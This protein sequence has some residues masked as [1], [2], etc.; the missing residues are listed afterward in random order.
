ML[1]VLLKL[2]PWLYLYGG[3]FVRNGVHPCLRLWLHVHFL[4]VCVDYG[5]VWIITSQEPVVTS[6]Q[7]NTRL[8]VVYLITL[9]WMVL[10]YLHCFAATDKRWWITWHRHS[11]EIIW[12]QFQTTAVDWLVDWKS[13]TSV[14][15][16]AT[17]GTIVDGILQARILEWV[18]SPFSRG[19]SQPR[20]RTEISR[21]AGSR[22]N[23]KA[24]L[25]LLSV[26]VASCLK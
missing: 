11:S 6:I 3:N 15:F 8:T 25:S 16:F 5:A 13:L 14:W 23:I 10:H 21:M 19:F 20:G 7:D 9:L 4:L 24:R 18:A 26:Q 12:V 1:S 17:P 2:F 22:R